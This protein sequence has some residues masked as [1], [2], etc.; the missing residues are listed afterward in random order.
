MDW[1]IASTP[2]S[3][4]RVLKLRNR[5]FFSYLLV[6]ATIL[7]VF[8]AAV[9]FVV[10]RDRDQQITKHLH[11]VAESSAGTLEIILHEYEELTTEPK[12]KGYI[13][14]QWDGTPAPILLTELMNMYKGVSPL[15]AS[16]ELISTMQQ[17][18]EW[19][20]HQRRLVVKEGGLFLSIPLPVVIPPTGLLMQ[21]GDIRS[22]IRPVYRNAKKNQVLGYVRVTE[23]TIILEAELNRLRW[24]LVIGVLTVSGLAMLAGMGLTRESLKPIVKSFNQLQ[25]FTADASHELRNPLTAIRASIAVIESHP[26]RIHAADVEKITAIA[27]ASLQMSHLVDDLLLGPDGSAGSQSTGSASGCPG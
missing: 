18:V 13:P 15:K 16:T 1:D 22:L 3:N 6:I 14:I 17:G 19:Y 24:G 8:S 25:Q 21:Q 10:A 23:S 11:Q 5:L 12:Y 7:G 27:H 4:P 26:E 9:Y 2:T 20:N